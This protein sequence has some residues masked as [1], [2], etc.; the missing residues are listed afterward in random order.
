MKILF[1][2]MT[3]YP[4]HEGNLL[5]K[6]LRALGHDAQLVSSPSRMAPGDASRMIE[7]GYS[8]TVT[9][10]DLSRGDRADPALYLY[11][12]PLGLIPLGLDSAPFPTA[13]FL[14]DLHRDYRSRVLLG[15]FFD[16]AFLAQRDY[17]N[18]YRR[19]AC[20]S[21]HWMPLACDPDIHRA[22]HQPRTLDVGFVGNLGGSPERQALLQRLSSEFQL[23][24]QRFYTAQEMVQIY[25]RA[26]VVINWPVGNDLNLRVF[27]AMSCGA[28]LM[29]RRSGNGQ[30]ILFK[31][32]EHLITVSSI[33]EAV[34]RIRYYLSHEAERRAIAEAG[35]SLVRGAHTWR[36]RAQALLDLIGGN[37]AGGSLIR[38]CSREEV[39]RLYGRLFLL[40]RLVDPIIALMRTSR[41]EGHG[42]RYLLPYLIGANLRALNADL[43]LLKYVRRI[44]L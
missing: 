4:E 40:W 31:D 19:D 16:H 13:C 38:R 8:Q 33:E 15:K 32:G 14:V 36:H 7:P 11:Y 34:D 17:V 9:L 23:N 35:Y 29:T 21:A 18:R 6:A 28:M 43:Q 25:S 1:S 27:E 41:S 39:F 42:W 26:R 10:G 37:P 24:E 22:D 2:H 3:G 30:E 44:R 12:E 5:R 20:G